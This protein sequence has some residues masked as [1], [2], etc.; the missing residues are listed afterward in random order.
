ML[1]V[2]FGSLSGEAE[3]FRAVADWLMGSAA[4][5]DTESSSVSTFLNAMNSFDLN[6]Y[7]RAIHFDEEICRAVRSRLIF[8]RSI[9][10]SDR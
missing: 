6:E 4:A 1:G 7:I 9:S 8:V 2:P 10:G 3:Y 5:E